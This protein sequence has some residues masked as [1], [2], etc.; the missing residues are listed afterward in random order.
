M[1]VFYI[2]YPNRRW[3]CYYTVSNVDDLSSVVK[4]DL[5]NAIVLVVD[6]SVTPLS[7]LV[8]EK[9]SY[10]RLRVAKLRAKYV[11]V[12][13]LCGK[14]FIIGGEEL[15]RNLG[16]FNRYEHTVS[17][18]DNIRPLRPRDVVVLSKL[19]KNIELRNLLEKAYL[20]N[21]E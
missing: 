5:G 13:T 9:T 15:R 7:M 19:T 14:V 16:Y 1:K 21:I 8:T 12:N 10:N 11:V 17:F 18:I 20:V 6:G 3:Q 2:I 4:E